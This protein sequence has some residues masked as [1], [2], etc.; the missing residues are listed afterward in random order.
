[1]KLFSFVCLSALFT[2]SL[3][4]AEAEA[5]F[6]RASDAIRGRV[7]VALSE[8][9]ALQES[10]AEEKLPLQRDLNLL[11]AEV[12]ALRQE[13]ERKERLRATREA[14]VK[15]G[16]KELQTRT[17]EVNYVAGLLAEYA[18]QFET[19]I[20]ISE[21][22]LYE[23]QIERVK[24]AA[25][26]P[27]LTPAEKFEIQLPLIETSLNRFERLL[28]GDQFEGRALADGV[29]VDGTFA[30]LGPIAMFAD[31][32]GDA[33]GLVELQFGSP[34]PSVI[35][36]GEQHTAAVRNV[37]STGEGDLPIDT[38][39]GNARKLAATKESLTEHWAKGGP[40]M[41]PILLL[42]FISIG[43]GIFKWWQVSQ[44]KQAGPR[45]L[46]LVLQYLREG[47]RKKALDHADAIGGPAGRM[48]QKAIEHADEEK[49]LIEEVLYEQMLDTRP[50]LEKW[51]PVIAL[52]A[53]TAPLLGL[54]GTVTGMINTFKLISVF[55]TGDPRMLS[56]GISEALVTTEYGL[57]V[58][59]PALLIHAVISRKT[60]GVL[61]GMEQV[62]VGFVNGVPNRNANPA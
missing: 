57:I 23:D 56:S 47:Q 48:L 32:S 51:M 43:I 42:G 36:L 55:G 54:L 4:A 11:E 28:G 37:V 58:A 21:V 46:E 45:D 15:A 7:D 52:T 18:R 3:V 8:L 27:N 59:I 38:S 19:R 33:A 13:V 61:G 60:K 31:Q 25:E 26:D 5:E 50:R 34:E 17:D 2:G 35:P 20:H 29:M 1:M 12:I 41:I 62:A 9:A 6:A 16:E 53:A 49:E 10:I 39:M 40:V 30:L 24:L 22:Q 44:V 14:D